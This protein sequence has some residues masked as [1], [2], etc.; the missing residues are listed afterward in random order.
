MTTAMDQ[1]KEKKYCDNPMCIHHHKQD[2]DNHASENMRA[3]H[4]GSTDILICRTYQLIG[5]DGKTLM[6][7][8]LCHICGNVIEMIKAE[9][10]FRKESNRSLNQSMCC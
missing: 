8:N 7:Q 3:A 10:E 4:T 2:P 1:V 5:R 6:E 9:M